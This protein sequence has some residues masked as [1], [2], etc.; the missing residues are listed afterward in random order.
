MSD[1]RE[2][3]LAAMPGTR[4]ELADKT[5]VAYLVAFRAVRALLREKKAH[6]SGWAVG[7]PGKPMAVLSAGAGRAAPNPS[8]SLQ[9]MRVAQSRARAKKAG[10]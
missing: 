6:V 3:I 8:Q 5:G 7:H 9:A 1:T 2:K 10:A 4:R